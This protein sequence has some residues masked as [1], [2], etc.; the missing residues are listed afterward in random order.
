MTGHKIIKD[1]KAAFNNRLILAQ[2][3]G[4]LGQRENS[5]S[6][7]GQKVVHFK[8]MGSKNIPIKTNNSSQ[9]HSQFIISSAGG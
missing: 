7:S 6:A 4:Q 3:A 2:A 1:K 9:R 5:F 8:E